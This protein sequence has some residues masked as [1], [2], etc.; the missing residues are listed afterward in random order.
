ML[1]EA[2]TMA[3]YGLRAYIVNAQLKSLSESSRT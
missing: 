3:M 1:I 2:E